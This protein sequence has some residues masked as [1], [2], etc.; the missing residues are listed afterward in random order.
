MKAKYIQKKLILDEN[1]I[2]T[3]TGILGAG[4]DRVIKAIDEQFM[5]GDSDGE[6]SGGGWKKLVRQKMGGAG[7]GGVICDAG[8]IMIGGN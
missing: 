7:G 8:E 5:T 1:S 4:H 6:E 2:I 3:K